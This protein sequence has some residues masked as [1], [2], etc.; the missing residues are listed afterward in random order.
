MKQTGFFI[1]LIL[2]SL[3]AL[4]VDAQKQKKSKMPKADK[5]YNNAQYSRAI[6]L[7]KKAYTKKTKQVKAEA[8]FKCAE[9]YR[10]ISDYKEA[11]NWYDKAVK[12]G[13]H[14]NKVLLAYGD[15][16]KASGKYDEAIVQYNN[17]KAKE[18]TDTKVDEAIQA[19]T[20][21]QGWK[22]KPTRFKVNGFTPMNTK[23]R[24]FGAFLNPADK[25]MMYFTSSREEAAGDDNDQWIG[26]KYFDLFK[27]VKDNNGKWSMPV[28]VGSTV[29]SDASD[30]SACVDS[31]GTTIYLSRVPKVKNKPYIGKIYK[32]TLNGTTWSEPEG[33]SFNG[34]DFTVGQP[35]LS[36]DDNTM[37][38]VSDM[39]GGLGGKDIWMSIY[40]KDNSTWG[41]PVNLGSAVNTAGD[42]MFP[43]VAPGGKLYFSSNGRAGMGGLDIFSTINEGGA[44]SEP[45]NMMSPVNSS[46]DDFSMFWETKTTGYLSSDRE[47]G[48]GKDDIYTFEVP[49]P[50]FWIKGKV[51]DT[52]TKAPIAGAKVEL[53][54]S[55]GTNLSF[56]TAEDGNYRYDLK[57]EVKYKVSASFTGYL[58]KFIE[59]STVGLPDDK[60]FVGDFDFPLKSH[61]E[62]IELKDI[63]YDLDKA[64]LRPESK[65]ELDKLIKILDD[66]PTITINIMSHT[67]FRASDS[68]N[69]DL[70]KRRAKSVVDYLIKSGVDKDRLTSQGM[71]ETSPRVIKITVDNA[72]D[73]APFKDGDVLSEDFINK[74]PKADVEKAHQLNR[75]TEFKVS[76]LNFVPKQ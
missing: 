32:T 31:K 73:M 7:Y 13:Y 59:V 74:L 23:Y 5:A 29:N 43:V 75:R 34:E 25:T 50:V 62:A 6:D 70:S 49:P 55:D 44:W 67:D 12:A 48:A 57:P 64:T 65:A 58:T 10:Q 11:A 54:G 22:D 41:A 3:F 8:A 60:E 28:L 20:M 21:A 63:F 53:F 38:F 72:N 71:G 24:D 27:S 14:D 69:L 30:G 26:E 56:I 4:P 37:Y 51:Y 17:Y 76:G 19:A 2:A 36:E 42:E 66:N 47:G 1:A 35:A 15:A 52:D 18:P 40:N 16:L 39:P 33:V 68:Y 61:K 46:G 45:V 9:S